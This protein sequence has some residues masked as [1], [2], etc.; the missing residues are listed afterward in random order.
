MTGENPTE[1]AEELLSKST[2]RRST[3]KKSTGNRFKF[4]GE[5]NPGIQRGP[6]TL[7]LYRPVEQDGAYVITVDELDA[8]SFAFQGKIWE[9]L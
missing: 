2:S 7:E 3:T 9:A 6:R 1:D 4:L 8:P 5:G